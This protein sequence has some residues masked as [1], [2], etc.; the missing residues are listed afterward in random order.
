M[1]THTLGYPRMGSNRELKKKLESYWRG[2]AGADDLAL[3]SKNFVLSIGK[4]SLK[5]E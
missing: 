4:I 2:E 5:P 3:T 1:L